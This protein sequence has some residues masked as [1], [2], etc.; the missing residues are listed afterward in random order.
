[1]KLTEVYYKGRIRRLSEMAI[2]IL[3]LEKTERNE[4]IA[5]QKLPP[6]LEIIKIQKKEVLPPVEVKKKED[7]I[8][9]STSIETPVA[10][11]PKPKKNGRK[12]G[13]KK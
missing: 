13:V 6:N 2:E 3:G 1:M 8:V 11:K 12:V 9:E 7:V 10:E 4:P 5:I